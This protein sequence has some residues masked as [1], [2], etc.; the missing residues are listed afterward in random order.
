MQTCTEALRAARS[1]LQA[2]GVQDAWLD[3]ELLVCHVLRVERSVLHAQ[4]E[5]LLADGEIAELEALLADP[6]STIC[7]IYQ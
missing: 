1:S 4:P 3:A 7:S 5:R 6:R 2:S